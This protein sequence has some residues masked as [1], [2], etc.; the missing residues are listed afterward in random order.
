V[1]PSRRKVLFVHGCFWHQHRAPNCK[2]AHVPK[3]RISYWGPKLKRNTE[4]DAKNAQLLRDLGWRVLT[5]WA[6]EVADEKTL[7]SKLQRFLK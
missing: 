1:F 2:D 7:A 5:V 3:S 4:R 6:C